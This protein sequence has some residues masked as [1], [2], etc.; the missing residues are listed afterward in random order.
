MMVTPHLEDFLNQQTP[1]KTQGIAGGL[2]PLG[3]GTSQLKVIKTTKN[4]LS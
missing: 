1:I 3:R 4:Q 2:T